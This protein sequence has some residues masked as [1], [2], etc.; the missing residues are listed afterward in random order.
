MLRVIQS[1]TAVGRPEPEPFGPSLLAT[2]ACPPSSA[3]CPSQDGATSRCYWVRG[4][5]MRG[6]RKNAHDGMTL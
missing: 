6:T 4:L 5:S 2:V 1:S 3:R